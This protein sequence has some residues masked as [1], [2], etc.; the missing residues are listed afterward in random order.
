[1]GNGQ[2]GAV[3]SVGRT[4]LDR[5]AGNPGLVTLSN[6]REVLVKDMK[7]R[8]MFALMRIITHGAGGMLSMQLT[9]AED[10]DELKGAL[11]GI[12]IVAIPEATETSLNFIRMIVEPANLDS[13]SEEEKVKERA[14]LWEELENPEFEDTISILES[15]LEREAEDLYALGKRLA[16]AFWAAR[17][18]GLD[19]KKTPAS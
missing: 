9:T 15:I 10:A 8:E 5:L 3:D 18:R 13:L 4:D 19:L 7:T 11:I 14:K 6:G 17:S 2:A 1:V 12:L 16:A